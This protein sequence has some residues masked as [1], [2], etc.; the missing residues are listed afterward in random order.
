MQ[1]PASQA[2]VAA[3]PSQYDVNRAASV[4][5]IRPTKASA[6]PSAVTPKPSENIITTTA[7]IPAA[8]TK[9]KPQ[10][11]PSSIAA[12]NIPPRTNKSATLRA[13][14]AATAASKPARKVPPSGCKSIAA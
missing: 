14:A 11:R 4:A 10:P 8:A 12:P 5:A 1:R 9:P 2:S 13:A 7:T 6:R 3:T